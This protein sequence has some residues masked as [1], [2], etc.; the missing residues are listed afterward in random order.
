M[1]LCL[2]NHGTNPPQTMFQDSMHSPV[3][4]RT[5][6]GGTKVT[7]KARGNIARSQSHFLTQMNSAHLAMGISPLTSALWGR[8]CRSQSPDRKP[9]VQGLLQSKWQRDVSGARWSQGPRLPLLPQQLENS[10][11]RIASGG[12]T[13]KTTPSWQPGVTP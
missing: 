10:R 5:P 7:W 12:F 9:P 1:S 8:G 4:V 13:W 2:S 3:H 6:R 11:G